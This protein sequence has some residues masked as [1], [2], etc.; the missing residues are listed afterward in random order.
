MGGGVGSCEAVGYVRAMKFSHSTQQLASVGL[1]LLWCVALVLYRIYLA[2][3]ML[4]VGLLWNLFLATLPLLWGAAFER[5]LERERRILAGLY[6][7]LW[8]LFLPNAP[9]I[10]TDMIH[11]S[12]RPPVPLWY[13]LAMLL[14]CAGTGTLLGYLSLLDVHA[15]VQ[16]KWGKTAGWLVALSALWMS[17]A[18]IYVGRFLRWNSWDALTHPLAVAQDIAT[19]FTAAGDHPHPL[20]VTIVF[21]TGLILGYLALRVLAASLSESSRAT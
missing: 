20:A 21:S 4:A 1:L 18:G 10:L 13:L 11:L 15:V 6:F 8:L 5:A 12:P 3:D 7:V 16:R 17:G 9:Y 19:Q 14:S 2:A